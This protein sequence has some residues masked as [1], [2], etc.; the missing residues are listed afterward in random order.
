MHMH[1]DIDGTLLIL[2]AFKGLLKLIHQVTSFEVDMTFQRVQEVVV[3][4]TTNKKEVLEI[5]EWEMVIYYK[6]VQ[7]A[8]TIMRVY[9][10]H[11]DAVSYEKLFDAVQKVML[12]LTGQSIA[13]KWLR[14]EGNLLAMVVDMEIAQVQGAAALF[15]KTQVPSHSPL[16]GSRPESFPPYFVK[17]CKVHAKR[18]LHNY[19]H[20]LDKADY[21]HIVSYMNHIKTKQDLEDFHSYILSLKN[22]KL[23]AWWKHKRSISWILPCTIRGLSP[24]GEEDWDATSNHTN[25]SEGQHAWTKRLTDMHHKLVTAIK[26]GRNVDATV[27]EEVQAAMEC[28]LPNNTQNE[29]LHRQTRNTSHCSN[30]ANKA[31]K[32]A[33][34]VGKTAELQKELSSAQQQLDLAKA[35]RDGLKHQLKETKLVTTSSGAIRKNRML[36]KT[37]EQSSSSG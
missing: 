13:F 35:K 4:K 10:N 23:T 32:A 17:L 27:L 2:A 29:L 25:T 19:R 16:D 31:K 37:Q 20:S 18:G 8:L 30:Q 15:K 28:R 6:P 7:R 1:Q 3:R 12:E 33:E 36:K 22:A 11:S 24:V 9:T 26:T 14:S 5:N 21:D 34:Q